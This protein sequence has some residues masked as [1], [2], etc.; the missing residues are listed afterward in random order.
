MF[1]HPHILAWELED[2]DDWASE[3]ADRPM[4]K[5]GQTARCSDIQTFWHVT[6]EFEGQGV[7]TSEHADRPV[8]KGRQSALANR[9]D[10]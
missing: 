9:S 1:G 2:Q 6:A 7:R 4:L 3:H 5:G 8:L 10:H